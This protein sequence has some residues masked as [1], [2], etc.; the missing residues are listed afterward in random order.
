M[1]EVAINDEPVTTLVCHYGRERSRAAAEAMQTIG[2]KIN[3][4]VG[5]TREIASLPVEEIKKRIKPDTNLLLI[6]DQGSPSSEFA[7]KEAAVKKLDQAG[8]QYTT[9]DTAQLGIMLYERGLDL[10]DYLY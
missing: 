7:H 6:Y 8:I 1:S 5:G 3:H 4:F 2:A 10:N 9:I